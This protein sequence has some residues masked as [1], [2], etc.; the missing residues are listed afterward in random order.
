M[1]KMLAMILATLMVLS[2][3]ACGSGNQSGV[4][5]GVLTVGMECA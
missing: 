4:E 5:D 2:L 1:K 3:A